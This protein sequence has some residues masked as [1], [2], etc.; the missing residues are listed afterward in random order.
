MS[1]RLPE[2]AFLIWAAVVVGWY[3]SLYRD[4]IPAVLAVLGFK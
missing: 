3:V 2:A 4:V 1:K